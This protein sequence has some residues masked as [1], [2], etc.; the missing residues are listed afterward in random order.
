V[1]TENLLSGVDVRI[2]GT[3]LDPSIAARVLEVRVESHLMLPDMFSLRIPD[4][5]VTL[6]DDRTF[7][8]GSDAEV[9]FQ[10]PDTS[11]ATSVFKGQITSLEPDFDEDGAVMAV[12]GYDRS[13]LLNGTPRTATYQSV[14]FG[15]IAQTVAARGGL[16]RGTI[17]DAGGPQDFIQQSSETDWMFL[18]RLAT[19]IGFEVVVDGTTLHFRHAGGPTGGRPIPL[20][21]GV[22]LLSFRPRATGIGQV[23]EVVVRGWDPAVGRSI[24]GTASSPAVT[25]E[26]GLSRR[27]V[28]SAMGAG[29]VAVCDHP[30]TSPEHATAVAEGIAGQL[31]D[32]FVDA[33][34]LAYGDP[35]LRAGA[36]VSVTGVGS[37]FAGVYALSETTHMFRAGR[38]YHTQLRVCGRAIPTLGAGNRR[39]GWHHSIVV[40]VVTN[41]NDPSKLG[42]IRVKYPGLDP[43]HEGWWARMT[44]PSAGAN[45]G[46]LMMPV[47][48]DEVVLAFEH[49]ST[50]HPYILGSVWNGQASPQT[51]FQADGSFSLRSDHQLIATAA[52]QITVA[53]DQA[54]ALQAGTDMTIKASGQLSA[55]G[56]AT[57]LKA[58]TAL[59][60]QGVESVKLT[61]LQ[62]SVEA[63]AN[64]QLK[65]GAELQ[66]QSGAAL[67]ITGAT[68]QIQAT[69]AIEITAPQIILG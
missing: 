30:V 52:E 57:A 16:A 26:I 11:S 39:S 64:A 9:L 53:G 46:L 38:G 5:D 24:V 35:R 12:R 32:T 37:Q 2:G 8:I 22:D 1:S 63:D 23:S 20:A 67:A 17:D 69:A 50:E 7:A 19:P 40:G 42:R 43:D 6:I 54:V 41:N 31:A 27:R 55:E 51:L 25:S 66:L 14:T 4:P 10:A 44:A 47:V 58:A 18:W 61:G 60:L 29:S 28:V 49:D 21:W 59:T 68:I 45:R 48:G 34:G 65:A 3:S 62:V 36:K 13:H 56:E 15:D 33:S